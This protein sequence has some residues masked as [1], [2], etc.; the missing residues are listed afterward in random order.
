[1]QR[2]CSWAQLQQSFFQSCSPPTQTH[3]P[4][5]IRKTP[6]LKSRRLLWEYGY[7]DLLLIIRQSIKRSGNESEV[8]P[9]VFCLTFGVYHVTYHRS[10]FTLFD[11]IDCVFVPKLFTYSVIHSWHFGF[12]KHYK[13]IVVRFCGIDKIKGIYG[14]NLYY[15]LNYYYIYYNIYNNKISS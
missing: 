13:L 15:Y 4:H 6:I 5:R 7:S 2:R 1:M 3:V 14:T 9:K 12:L 11:M 8:P 10:L